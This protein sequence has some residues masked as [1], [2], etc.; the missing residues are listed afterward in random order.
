MRLFVVEVNDGG[1]E[2]AYET[3]ETFTSRLR[4]DWGDED[5]YS[6]MKAL[7][8]GLLAMISIA[9]VG[10]VIPFRLGWVFCAEDAPP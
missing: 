6:Q 3:L 7:D 10:M 9:H 8:E 5:D 1:A 2:G 4:H